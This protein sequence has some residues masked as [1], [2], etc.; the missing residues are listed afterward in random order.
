MSYAT[1]DGKRIRR[2]SAHL[3]NKKICVKF[4]TFSINTTTSDS[5]ISINTTISNSNTT[6]TDA[7]SNISTYQYLMITPMNSCNDVDGMCE[8]I[9]QLQNMSTADNDA[10]ICA[11]CGKK[12]IDVNN[13][14]NKC[15]QVKYCNAVCKKKHRQ[16]TRKIVR[17]ISDSLLKNMI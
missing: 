14:C 5:N 6:I 7:N 10:S 8:V 11:N 15:K 1:V 9:G 16:S 13:I 3:V 2:K 4:G 17:N 12:G